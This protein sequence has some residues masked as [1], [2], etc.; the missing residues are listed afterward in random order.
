M[1][2]DLERLKAD[3]KKLRHAAESAGRPFP[4]EAAGNCRQHVNREL[5]GSPGYSGEGIVPTMIY[6]FY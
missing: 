4:S 5:D 6:Y 3:T 1:G 2:F